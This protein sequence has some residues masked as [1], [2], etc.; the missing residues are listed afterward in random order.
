MV[1]LEAR[2]R[3]GGQTGRRGGHLMTW[4]VDKREQV[5]TGQPGLVHAMSVV[6]RFGEFEGARTPRHW[7]VP[8]KGDSRQLT[9]GGRKLGV[10]LG[11][12]GQ[13]LLVLAHALTA[14][15]CYVLVPAVKR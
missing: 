10:G 15:A 5:Q 9:S 11:L 4:C 12:T 13:A 1:L 6:P 3:G 14:A 2:V 7:L 8:P